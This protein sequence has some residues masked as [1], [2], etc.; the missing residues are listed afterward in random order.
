MKAR[1]TMIVC[2][3][4]AYVFAAPAIVYSAGLDGKEEEVEKYLKKLDQ[5]RGDIIDTYTPMAKT[6][7]FQW[8]VRLSFQ[9]VLHCEIAKAQALH[10]RTIAYF[11]N[12]AV[13]ASD[14]PTLEPTAFFLASQNAI[15]IG[16][17]SPLAIKR[18]NRTI[19]EIDSPALLPVAHA[20]RERL[21]ELGDLWDDVERLDPEGFKEIKDIMGRAP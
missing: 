13:K 20:V 9:L 11:Y 14:C 4:L 7:D 21:R 8:N 15:V 12:S 2:G 1:T 19:K 10:L 18:L 6:G 16:D 5:T 3:F 17:Y